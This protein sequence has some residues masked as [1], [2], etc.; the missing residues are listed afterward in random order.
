MLSVFTVVPL[1]GGFGSDASAIHAGQTLLFAKSALL[2]AARIAMMQ[3]LH[4]C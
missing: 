3:T 2:Q 4:E 1:W